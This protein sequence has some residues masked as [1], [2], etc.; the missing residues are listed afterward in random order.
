M[1]IV[2]INQNH[3]SRA[4][5]PILNSLG[6]SNK[7][8]EATAYEYFNNILCVQVS[9]VLNSGMLKKPYYDQL[10]RRKVFKVVRKGGNGRTAL[11]EYSSIRQD[12]KELIVSLAGNPETVSK[13][14]VLEKYITPNYE[15]ASFFTTYRKP[16][17]KSLGQEKQEEYLTNAL[18]LDAIDLCVQKANETKRKVSG[19]KTKLWQNIADAV[20]EL[21]LTKYQHSIPSNPRSIERLYKKYKSEGYGSL[22]HGQVDNDNRRKISGSVAD[23]LLATYCLPNKPLVSMVTLL[24]NQERQKH[25]WPSLSESAVNLFLERPEN[26]RIWFL[27]RHG[28]EAYK[29][30]YSHKLERDRS[31]WFPNAYWAI[32]GTKLDWIHY[33]DNASGMAAKLK[34]DPVFDVYSEKIIGYSISETEDHTDHFRALKMAVMNTSSRPFK[35]TYDNQSGHKSKR[36]QELY[37]GIVARSGG[38]HNPTRPY[39]SSNPAEQIFNRFQQQVIGQF[40]FSDKQSVTVRDLDN[41]P[42]MDFVK[43]NKHR[44]PSREELIKA[45]ELAVKQWNEAIHPTQKVSRNEVYAQSAPYSEAIDSIEIMNLFWVNETQ[46]ITYKADGITLKIAGIKHSFEVY[47]S[48]NSIDLHWRRYNVGRKFIVRYDPEALDDYVQLLEITDNGDKALVAMAQPKRKHQEIPVLMKDGDKA[49]WHQDFKVRDEELKRDQLELAAL[50]E[51]TGI[52]PE[53]LID[54]QELAIKMG[55]YIPKDER[56]ESDSESIFL[57]L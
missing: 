9:W 31:E 2:T 37:N 7:L 48:E 14:G 46:E 24:Y 43:A 41:K 45:W 40:W 8:P 55:G 35:L 19:A 52:T 27:A 11:I 36:M 6:N 22:I 21:P 53:R 29:N 56:S 16:N 10:V 57:R 15:A 50:L 5:Q 30:K 28:K 42:N 54:E 1:R 20:N 44:L 38:T 18:I 32:D 33:F 34:M 25:G 23:W 13:M 49:L 17:G 47:D 12:F 26:K 4:N 3:V 39:E 51:R